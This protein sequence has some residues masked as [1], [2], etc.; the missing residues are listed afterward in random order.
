MQAEQTITPYIGAFGRVTGYQLFIGGGFASPLNPNDG[1]H[2]RLNFG[3]FQGGLDFT[4][5]PGTHLFVSGGHDVA[6]SDAAVIEGDFSTWLWLHSRHPIN[7]SFSSLYNWQNHVESSSIDFQTIAFSSEKWMLL[8]G[9]GG[10]FYVGGF[11]TDPAGQGGP[12]LGF[13]YRPWGIGATA[14]AG[15][16]TA[17]QYGQISFY[18]QLSFRE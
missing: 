15:Y 7:F 18:K 16:G 12:D 13:Y 1:A 10:A 9:A 5:A 8:V 11:L 3:R 17:H 6:D 14:Q 2:S 4:L